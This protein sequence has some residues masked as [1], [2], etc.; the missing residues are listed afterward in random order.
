MW[1]VRLSRDADLKDVKGTITLADGALQFSSRD[2]KGDRRID[3]IDVVRVK[4]VIGSPVMLVT[5]SENGEPTQTAFYFSQPPP[6]RSAD[7]KTSRR[8]L[9]R[10]A[11]TYL[12][13]TNAERG[14]TVRDWVQAI[15]A[16]MPAR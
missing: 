5:H 16:E 2:G 13:H 12:G 8:K 7:E 15:R 10:Q 1:V 14:T 3:L 4:R 9:R 11:A 6:L